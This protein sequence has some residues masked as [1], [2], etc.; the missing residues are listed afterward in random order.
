MHIEKGKI[1]SIQLMYLVIGLLQGSTLTAAFISGVTK[2]DTW[3]VILVSFFIMCGLLLG[4]IKLAEVFPEKNIIEIN[5]ITYGKYIGKVISVIYIYHFWFIVAANLRIIGDFYGS[6]L[7]QETEI[8]I[9][10]VVLAITCIYALKKGLEVISRIVPIFVIVTGIVAI[11]ISVLL[12][13]EVDITNLLPIMQIKPLEFIHG[14]DLIVTI[15]FG[16]IM[17]FLMIFPKVKNKECIKEHTFLGFFI[18]VALF[19]MV[20]V[21]NIAVLGGSGSLDIQ[22]SYQVTKIINIGDI[23]TRAE[24]IVAVLLLTNVFIK[25]AIFA[26]ATVMSISQLFKL[27]SYKHIVSPIMAISALFAITMYNSSVEESFNA[28]NIYVFYGWIPEIIFPLGSL[29]ISKVLKLRKNN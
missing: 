4:Y 9:F 2:Q 7:M 1:S 6:F 20:I 23:I 19:F 24:V 14:V 26:Y 25:I 18:G 17:V 3:I 12:I 15:P 10:I 13:K 16:E 11:L 8:I 29:L 28:T 21:R 5:D 22:S 27:R